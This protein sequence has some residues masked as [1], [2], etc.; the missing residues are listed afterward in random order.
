MK[1]REFLAG[2]GA[3]AYLSVALAQ[4]E[5]AWRIGYLASGPLDGGFDVFRRQMAA[6]G[7]RKNLLID[8]R[9]ALG[10]YELLSGF[11]KELVDL[12]PDVIVAEATPAIAAVQRATATIPIV[13]SPATDPVG[14]GFVKNFAHPGGNITGIAN[15][16]GDLTAKSFDFLHLVLPSAKSVAILM[17]S[18]PTHA[19]LFE[20]ANDGA[21]RIGLSAIPFVAPNPSDLDRV[22]LE[23]K[24][25]KCDSLYVLA[26][27]YR[28]K[29]VELAA[30]AQIPAIYQYSLFVEIGGLMSYGPDVL[31]IFERAAGY[32]DKILKGASPAD[33]PV[34]Q[35]T[36]FYFTLNLKTARILGITIPESVILLADKVIE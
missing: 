11:A 25:A 2:L 22:F 31:S 28:P 6:L 29:I 18:N 10:N 12:H 14:S 35:P 4:Q 34:E 24:K 15:M 36:R 1:R 16:F 21:K 26:D 20:V 8:A 5:K 17:S 32:V 23:I 9:E 19:H 27:P 33:F 3:A 30:T 13:M 7:Y